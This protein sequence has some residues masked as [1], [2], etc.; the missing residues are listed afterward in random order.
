MKVKQIP[1]TP[2]KARLVA[3]FIGL[4]FV[5]I[6]SRMFREL[7]GQTAPIIRQDII[8]P[9]FLFTVWLAITFCTFGGYRSF[10]NWSHYVI[11]RVVRRGLVWLVREDPT[12][13]DRE[14]QET[15]Q[16]AIAIVVLGSIT[17]GM[18]L[19]FYLRYF[20]T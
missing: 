15:L 17:L 12:D 5:L 8:H 14:L 1:V 6:A 18:T 13:E 10:P 3:V 4:V 16:V 7:T 11:P 20:R 2:R 19:G 9:V